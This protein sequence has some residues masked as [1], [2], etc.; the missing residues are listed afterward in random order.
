MVAPLRG[1]APDRRTIA[2]RVR[3]ISRPRDDAGTET[4]PDAFVATARPTAIA[5]AA[6]AAR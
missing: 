1:R 4:E 3:E 6:P 2:G 5:E